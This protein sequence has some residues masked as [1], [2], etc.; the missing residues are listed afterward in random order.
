MEGHLMPETRERTE[1]APAEPPLARIHPAL[2][3]LLSLGLSYQ[4]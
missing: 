4:R 2:Y 3:A 1:H